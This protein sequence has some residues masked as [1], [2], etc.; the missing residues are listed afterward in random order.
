M[1]M[2]GFDIIHVD[3]LM[4]AE[5]GRTLVNR[6]PDTISGNSIAKVKS[7]FANAF[8]FAPALA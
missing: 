4:H 1:G 2:L 5:H 7:P 3:L 8:G 6:R